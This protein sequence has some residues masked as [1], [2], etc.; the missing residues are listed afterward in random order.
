MC[1]AKPYYSV[2]KIVDDAQLNNIQTALAGAILIDPSNLTVVKKHVIE[3][4]IATGLTKKILDNNIYTEIYM[5]D[6]YFIQK[7]Q[8]N[9][10]TKLHNFTLS[11]E[12]IMVNDLINQIKKSKIIK[13]LPV[14]KTDEERKIVEQIF[15]NYKDKL[16]I[17]WSTHPA[18]KGYFFGNITASGISKKQSILEIVSMY[19]IN[20]KNI[21]G[22]GDSLT[23]WDFIG[24]CG[25]AG[26]MGNATEDLKKLVLSKGDNG[27]IGK[28]VNEN[29][30]L[31][32]FNYFGL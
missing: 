25:Y 12:P 26:A 14:T 32:I 10:I 13:I 24:V 15:L 28:S 30:I 1:S 18:I 29:G 3:N 5:T 19:K 17:G 6:K 20:T 9:E 21:L 16:A 23:D 7:S 31:D 8:K 27:Y 11:F 2:K 22:V 4:N